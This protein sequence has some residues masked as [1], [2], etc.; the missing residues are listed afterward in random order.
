MIGWSGNVSVAGFELMKDSTVW[1]SHR[2]SGQSGSSIFLH[3][4]S[5]IPVFCTGASLF[6]PFIDKLFEG[7]AYASSSEKNDPDNTAMLNEWSHTLAFARYKHV[8]HDDLHESSFCSPGIPTVVPTCTEWITQ[9]EK[10]MAA[11]YLLLR[12]DDLYLY[13]NRLVNPII[14]AAKSRRFDRIQD[15]LPSH[16]LYKL[17]SNSERSTDT[18]PLNRRRIICLIPEPH[19]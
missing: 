6:R 3:I 17:Y 11:S 7:N 4:P 15:S 14:A 2:K 5:S 9:V 16:E 13:G 8:H 18:L 10:L 1:C 12:I 19:S